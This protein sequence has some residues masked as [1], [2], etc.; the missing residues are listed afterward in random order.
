MADNPAHSSQGDVISLAVQ[1]RTF[2]KLD[3]FFSG[4]FVKADT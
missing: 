1:T 3:P 2:G 4:S